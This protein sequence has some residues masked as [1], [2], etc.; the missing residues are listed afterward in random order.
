MSLATQT[1]SRSSRRNDVLPWTRWRTQSFLGPWVLLVPAIIMLGLLASTFMDD[2]TRLAPTRDPARYTWKTQ[3]LLTDS[4]RLLLDK[5]GPFTM[6]AGGY[7]IVTPVAGALLYRV[8][9]VHTFNFTILLMVG[10]PVMTSLSLAVFAYQRRGDLLLALLTLVASFCLFLTTPFF[11]YLD[12]IMALYFL[13]LA[14]PLLEPARRSWA[15]RSALALLVCLTTLSHPTTAA[16]F[17]VVL[18]VGAVLRLASTRFSVGRTL[19]DDG[20]AL[21]AAIVGGA[22]GAVCWRVGIWGAAASFSDALEVQPYPSSFFLARLGGWVSSV[23]PRVTIPLA[24][25]AVVFILWRLVRREPADTHTRM[26]LLWL[27]PLVGL[28]GS[29]LGYNYPYYRF[30]NATL[31]PMLLVG[32]G[33]WVVPRLLLGVRGRWRPLTA[34]VGVLLA[35]VMV[36]VLARTFQPAYRRW[37]SESPWIADSTRVALAS[38][39]GYAEAQPGRPI[40]FVIH[41]PPRLQRAWGLAKQY[42]DIA[43]AGLG[44][45]Q[46]RRTFFFAGEPGDFLRRKPTLLGY[47]TFDAVSRGYLRDAVAG[48]ARYPSQPMV[49]YVR[50]F[51]HGVGEGPSRAARPIGPDVLLITGPGA[52]RP[53]QA[54]L[55]AAS[56][57]RAV[58]LASLQ[59]GS[60]G[61]MDAK[62][63][64]R[65]LAGLALLVVVPGILAM[66][67]FHFRHFSSGLLLAPGLSLAL[68]VASATAV[69]AVRRAPF[70]NLDAWLSV[71][72]A[73]GAGAL[74]ALLAWRSDRRENPQFGLGP[75]P[76]KTAQQGP[77]R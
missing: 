38:V 16:A 55:S 60:S 9:A 27:L 8:A 68:C 7:R 73:T 76:G 67:C 65:V 36:G 71:G 18:G 32:M 35:V 24:A 11:G 12:N 25:L 31:A 30:I 37:S 5:Q 69:I 21:G 17:V 42:A 46:V 3:V 48:L 70:G 72:L 10:I 19:H 23:K 20:I 26:S 33:A 1:G 15:A 56:G 2:P 28:F 61:E 44:G 63:L 54:A 34:G 40:V 29:R 22:V 51:N 6:L 64:W 74:L 45:D 62:H 13:S 14:L 39:R 53:A 75:A 57:A 43:L 59:A 66:N 47:R 58:E 52:S 50:Q 77:V 41:P 49:F 4:P